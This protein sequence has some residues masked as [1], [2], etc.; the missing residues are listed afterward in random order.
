MP[1]F[2]ARASDPALQ[3]L[4]TVTAPN[5]IKRVLK[6]HEPFKRMIFQRRGLKVRRLFDQSNLPK[7]EKVLRNRIKKNRL[8]MR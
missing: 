8:W 6:A 5:R 7:R 4:E 1:L 2:Y 3:V